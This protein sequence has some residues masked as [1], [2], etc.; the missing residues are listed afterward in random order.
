M[1]GGQRMKGEVPHAPLHAF[2]LIFTL[3]ACYPI[4]WVFTIAFSGKQSLAIVN[5]PQN[6]SGMDRIRAITP[7][8]ESVSVSNFVSVMTER[9][10]SP[11]LLTAPSSPEPHRR[12]SWPG[13]G[14]PS[15]SS[16]PAGGPG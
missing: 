9:S 6:P 4:L 12:A 8:P 11:L 14:T 7:W 16:A 15:P 10:R 5:L 2:L 3:L 13:A 1:S